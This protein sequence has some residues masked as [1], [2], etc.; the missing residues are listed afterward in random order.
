M[1]FILKLVLNSDEINS[2]CQE[3]VILSQEEEGKEE[4]E[5]KKKILGKGKSNGCLQKKKRKKKIFREGKSNG[6]PLFMPHVWRS[7]RGSASLCGLY[8]E[9]L[10]SRKD[11][12]LS[13]VE[14]NQRLVSVM[15]FNDFGQL[16]TLQTGSQRHYKCH[17]ETLFMGMGRVSA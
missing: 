17:I 7:Q 1:I 9:L 8:H 5:R 10:D 4:K 14:S 3:G 16:K 13:R 15:S 11:L 2:I 12:F 6:C